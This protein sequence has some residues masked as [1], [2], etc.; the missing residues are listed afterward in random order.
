VTLSHSGN[1]LKKPRSIQQILL[2]MTLM[3]N[4]C[5]EYNLTMLLIA[6]V[7]ICV[8]GFESVITF[9]VY[10]LKISTR[11][12]MKETLKIPILRTTKWPTEEG[13]TLIYKA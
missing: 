4:T 8:H 2:V 3:E 13:Q 11:C 5:Q 6:L 10:T 1:G 12:S 9:I 7:S